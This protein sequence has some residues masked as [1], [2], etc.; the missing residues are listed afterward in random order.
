MKPK[1]ISSEATSVEIDRT[2]DTKT[3]TERTSP[4]WSPYSVGAAIGVLSW[5]VFAV[6][7][8]PLGVST[9]LSA[10]AGECAK[11]ILGA[12]AVVQ[13]AYW[14]KFPFNWDYGVLFLLGILLG[15]ALSVYTSRTFRF[16]KVPAPWQERFGPSV[17]KRMVAALLGG[18]VLMYGAR[19]A[20]GCTSGHGI[21]GSLQLAVSSW[22]FVV[23]MFVTGIGAAWVLFRKRA[24][25]E[26]TH[27]QIQP[28]TMPVTA[29][30]G[31]VL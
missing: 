27:A 16:E 28:G 4:Y 13:N 29:Q 23:V 31:V 26:E 2:T 12:E 25:R 17:W 30:K 14:S 5:I 18:A 6:V 7:N 21:S 3:S 11:P 10:A 22:L 8:Q 24:S 9:A 15:S 19:M 1:P 20:G